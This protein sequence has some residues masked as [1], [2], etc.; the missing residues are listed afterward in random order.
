MCEETWLP[1][2][3]SRHNRLRTTRGGCRV[4]ALSLGCRCRVFPSRCVCAAQADRAAGRRTV[5]KTPAERAK[6]VSISHFNF[7]NFFGLLV[8]IRLSA[9]PTRTIESSV[10]NGFSADKFCRFETFILK[11]LRTMSYVQKSSFRRTSVRVVPPFL[12]FVSRC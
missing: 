4:N 11:D 10:W 3:P 5:N 8:F 7:F 6:T 12:L 2:L 1:C 9:F